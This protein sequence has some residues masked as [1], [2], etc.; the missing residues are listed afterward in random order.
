MMGGIT[1][2]GTVAWFYALDSDKAEF[3]QV[4]GKPLRTV[5]AGACSIHEYRI[6]PH[7]VVAARMGSGCVNTTATVST[8]LALN[9]VDRVISTGPAGG[10]TA[11]AEPGTWLR[12][13]EVMAWQS[14]RAGDDGRIFPGEKAL[15]TLAYNQA[16]WPDG[17][18]QKAQP[19]KLVSGEAFIASTEMRTR[20]AAEHAAS[21]VEMNAYGLLAGI[22]G[23]TVKLLI[24]RIVSDHADEKASEDF[25]AFL[26]NYDGNGGKMV[27]EIIQKLP[28]EQNEPAAHDALRELL[29]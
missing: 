7:R 1:S 23:R 12:V 22:E 29:K 19:A 11:E 9:A 4:A 2:A 16:D 20:L 18:W 3:E 15:S 25:A 10:L 28:V 6:G 14:G 13:R 24:L 21:A 17:E 5:V 27:A 26:K 8:V